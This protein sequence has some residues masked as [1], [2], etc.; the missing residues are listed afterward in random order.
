MTASEDLMVPSTDSLCAP[1]PVFC[2]SIDML[3]LHYDVLIIIHSVIQ[4]VQSAVKSR[5]SSK[6]LMFLLQPHGHMPMLLTN[7]IPYRMAKCSLEMTF[8]QG[9]SISYQP[10]TCSLRSISIVND[11][12]K[13]APWI[14]SSSIAR[15]STPLQCQSICLLTIST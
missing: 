2:K 14:F 3:L 7:E 13:A 6:L 1:Q 15:P 10:A 4:S 8:L 9:W 12:G 5:A 11:D